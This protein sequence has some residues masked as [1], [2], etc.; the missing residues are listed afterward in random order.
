MG[1]ELSRAMR[2]EMNAFRP[3]VNIPDS[4]DRKQDAASR[5][6]IGSPLSMRT[7]EYRWRRSRAII[8]GD[9]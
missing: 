6:T 1:D 8:P 7:V 4:C 5:F 9:P 3:F 2:L